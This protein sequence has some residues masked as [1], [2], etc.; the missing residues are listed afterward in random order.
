MDRKA[1]PHA[2][3]YCPITEINRVLFKI[4]DF[5]YESFVGGKFKQIARGKF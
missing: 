5:V 3:R 4:W 1:A 2:V